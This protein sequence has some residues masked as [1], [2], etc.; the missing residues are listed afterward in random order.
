VGFVQ[1][2]Q[3][4]KNWQSNLVTEGAWAQQ[5]FFFGVV[6]KGKEKNNASFICGTNFAIRRKTLIEVGGMLEDNIA[7]DFVTSLK[8][9]G[10][11]WKSY[12]VSEVLCEGLAPEDMLSY[13]KQQLRWSRGSLQVIFTKNNP[14][15][16]KGLN[17]HQKL[18][19][20]ASALYYFNGLIVLID[21]IMPLIFLFLGIRA[22]AA[23]STS[24][25]IFFVPFMVV[26][27]YTL[28]LASADKVSF[29]T[30]SFSQSS[31][32][33]QLLALKSIVFGQNLKFEVTSKRKLKGNYF[34]LVYPHITYIILGIMGSFTALLRE[35]A[36]PSVLT[37]I[38]WV[39]V[40]AALFMPFILAAYRPE[41]LTSQELNNL[42]LAENE[43]S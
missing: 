9:H 28:K 8:I 15:I 38:A 23:T 21:L 5:S 39:M 2:P 6:M 18:E 35:G 36:N 24:F 11:G 13:F 26:N 29:R 7:E 31:F 25:A 20:L 1:S 43:K 4:Y 10:L 16:Q 12:Y 30:L 33:I 42:E 27:L 37:N 40:N 32:V 19:Y 14:L 17:W 22:V 34:N 41:G 3:Y